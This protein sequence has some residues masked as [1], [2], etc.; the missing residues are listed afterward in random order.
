MNASSPRSRGRPDLMGNRASL[1][2]YGGMEGIQESSM[3][4]VKNRSHTITAE[5]EIPGWQGQWSDRLPG[6]PFRRLE[7]LPEGW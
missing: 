6:G 5:V 1:T 3:I 7:P 2:L 4:D